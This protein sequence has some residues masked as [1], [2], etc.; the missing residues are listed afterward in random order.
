MQDGTAANPRRLARWMLVTL[1]LLGLSA[2]INYIDRGNLAT[3][4]PLIKDE[5]GLSTTELGFLLTAFFVTYMPMQILVG[6]LADL[7]GAARVLLAGFVIWSLAMAL[8]GLARTFA[9]MV[10]LRLLLGLGESVFFPTA[11][12]IIARN[13]PEAARGAA[14]SA[15]IVGMSAG[16]AAGVFFGGLLIGACG[17]RGYFIGFGLFSLLWVIPWLTV[18]QPH[19]LRPRE[20]KAMTGISTAALLRTRQLWMASLGHACGNYIWYFVLSWIPFYLVRERGWT[21]EQMA[22]I[23]GISYLSMALVAAANG[24]YTDR[25]FAS[26]ASRTR[27]CKAFLGTGLGIAGICTA[28]CVLSGSWAS[29]FLLVVGCSALGLS[30]PHQFIAAQALA[31]PAASGRWVAVQNCLGNVSGLIAPALTGFLVDQSGSF[32]PPFLIAAGVALLGGMVWAFGIR[33]IETIDWSH[34]Q[35]A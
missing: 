30:G 23:G 32:V 25:L 31:G 26:G 18:A 1:V 10:A 27:V 19:L 34:Q 17:W 33:E 28:A 21:L 8:T 12:S 4:A 5:L 15:V 6:W 35:S 11:S 2:F 22:V 7:Y 24:W 3:A 16:P 9:V 13:V 14:N 29:V 20:V